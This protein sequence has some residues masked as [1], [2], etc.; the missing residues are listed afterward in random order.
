M[1]TIILIAI[2]TSCNIQTRR[3][4]EAPS[5]G[6]TLE[7][8][9]PG[10][11]NYK[12]A[13]YWAYDTIALCNLMLNETDFNN[14]TEGVSIS[15]SLDSV[16]FIIYY[17][18]LDLH[19]SSLIK[20]D[21][22]LAFSVYSVDNTN[23]YHKLYMQNQAG[24]FTPDNTYTC[25]VNAIRTKDPYTF[26]QQFLKTGHKHITSLFVYS[27]QTKEVKINSVH[28]LTEILVKTP[29]AFLSK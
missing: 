12:A 8:A 26:A 9:F 10:I 25:T 15:E 2:T 7:L 5:E 22:I 14:F 6:I 23:M 11:S 16:Y 18:D 29:P 20:P 28:E 3:S 19:E 21:N 27:D 4:C 13:K 1:L 24:I 17:L